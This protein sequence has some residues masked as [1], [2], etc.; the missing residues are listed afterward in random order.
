MRM[1]HLK[2]KVNQNIITES[3]ESNQ[4]ISQD[5]TREDLVFIP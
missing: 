5:W 1:Q 4:N 2:N 3:N